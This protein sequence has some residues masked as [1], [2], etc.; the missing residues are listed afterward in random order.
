MPQGGP[1]ETIPAGQGGARPLAL[2]YG[3][4]LPQSED[5]KSH[6]YPIA[7]EDTDGREECKNPREHHSTVVTPW[8]PL[9]LTSRPRLQNVDS[10]GSRSFDYGQGTRGGARLLVIW[11]RYGQQHEIPLSLPIVLGEENPAAIAGPV[12]RTL[13]N[14]PMC[15]ADFIGCAAGRFHEKV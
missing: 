13:R 15:H 5:F 4:L 11:P 12:G 9:R 8:M 6:V 14:F 7:E 3:D 10:S 2:E 1:E